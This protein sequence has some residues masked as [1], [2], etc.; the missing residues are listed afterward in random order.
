MPEE[1]GRV[2]EQLNTKVLIIGGGMGGYVCA[3]LLGQL[4]IEHPPTLRCD[5]RE[6]EGDVA[7]PPA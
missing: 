3:I 4:G 1:R 2:P 7:N 5:E 6:G